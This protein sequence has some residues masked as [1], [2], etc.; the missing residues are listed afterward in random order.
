MDEKTLHKRLAKVA[1]N[2]GEFFAIMAESFCSDIAPKSGSCQGKNLKTLR[3][4]KN[5]DDPKPSLTLFYE[6]LINSVSDLLKEPKI[7]I[8]PDRGLYRV[9]FPALQSMKVERTNRRLSEFA[10]FLL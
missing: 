2:V 9:P 1:R 4:G 7:I 10:W 3:E 6:M 8:V 5:T